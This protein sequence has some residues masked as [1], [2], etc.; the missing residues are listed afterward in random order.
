MIACEIPD[1]VG[2]IH[3]EYKDSFYFFDNQTMC[4]EIHFLVLFFLRRV[5]RHLNLKT[6][7]LKTWFK[8]HC[9]CNR[10]SWSLKVIRGGVQDTVLRVNN[11]CRVTIYTRGN[12][13]TRLNYNTVPALFSY[14]SLWYCCEYSAGGFT[15]HV[16]RKIAMIYLLSPHSE[17]S[18]TATDHF[19]GA[20]RPSHAAVSHKASP[21]TTSPTPRK[22]RQTGKYFRFF[23][24][25]NTV[26]C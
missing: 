1:F 3:Y 16:G 8:Y 4:I 13:F 18:S 22:K 2:Y 10:F 12:S 7:S 5:T 23:L 19:Q 14:L 20:D 24:G 21:P 15:W 6:V 9:N 26:V 17:S 11:Q 25:D